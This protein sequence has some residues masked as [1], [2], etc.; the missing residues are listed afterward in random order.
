[1]M[2]RNPWGRTDYTEDWNFEDPRWTEETIVQVPFDVDPTTSNEEGIFF[3]EDKDFM[4]CFEDFQVAV[5][6][7]DEGYS[8]NWFD[9]EAANA[10]VH[11]YEIEIPRKDGEIYFSVETY[12]QNIIPQNCVLDEFSMPLVIF[13][14]LQNGLESEN[15]IDAWYYYDQFHRPIG[16]S[17]DSYE[18]GDV[19]TV[20]V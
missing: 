2:V 10:Q 8:N 17:E 20:Y 5:Y 16:V 18:A 4:R 12:Y 15:V 3:V 19:F 14:L 9:E 1:M 7:D 6:R 11:L 13:G